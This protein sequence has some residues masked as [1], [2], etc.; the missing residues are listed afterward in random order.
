MINVTI[1]IQFLARGY[2]K[3]ERERNL[4]LYF[5]SDLLPG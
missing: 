1:I 2:K 3:K 5:P 4:V